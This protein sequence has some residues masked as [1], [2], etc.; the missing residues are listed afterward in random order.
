MRLLSLLCILSIS[1]PYV[2]GAARLHRRHWTVKKVVYNSECK[3]VESCSG[4]EWSYSVYQPPAQ[5]DQPAS[6]SPSPSPP[7]DNNNSGGGGSTGDADK[8]MYLK[9][10][11]DIRGQHGA[12]PLQWNNTLETAA[13]KWANGCV[14]EHSRGAIGP[15]GEN[16]STGTGDFGIDAAVK[17]W[18]DEAGDYNP[19]NPQYSHFTQMVWKESTQ[20]GCAVATGCNGIFDGS[21]GPAKLYVCE[22]YPAG[23]VI[24]DFQSNVQA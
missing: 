12:G 20:V 11:N 16:L 7:S 9:L 6:P 14:F 2:L 5:Q 22:Y 4:G 24:G 1:T 10:H 8:D 18:T 17:L 13:Q 3:G 21:Y 23:N 19:S 15:F